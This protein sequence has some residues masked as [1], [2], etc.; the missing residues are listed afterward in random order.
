MIDKLRNNQQEIRDLALKEGEMSVMQVV[1]KL[2][3]EVAQK[4]IQLERLQIDLEKLKTQIS[5]T[6]SESKG[7]AGERDLYVDFKNVFPEDELER[8]KRGSASGDIV[9]RIKANNRILE[10]PIVFDNKEPLCVNKLDLLKNYKIISCIL[11][12]VSSWLTCS[13]T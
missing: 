5:R 2:R 10:I 3:T 6:Q 7:E 8:Q 1:Q 4:N 11:V 9:Q 13:N 12:Y